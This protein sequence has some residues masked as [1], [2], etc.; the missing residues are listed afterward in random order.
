MSVS[1]SDAT[2]QTEPA[3]P[4]QATTADA[5]RA[6]PPPQAP[7]P[8]PLPGAS[9][10]LG[11]AGRSFWPWPVLALLVVASAGALGPSWP[12]AALASVA[13]LVVGLVGQWSVAGWRWLAVPVLVAVGVG[14][15]LGLLALERSSGAVARDAERGPDGDLRG[16]TLSREMLGSLD[17]VGRDLRGAQLARLDLRRE[18]LRGADAAGASFADSSLAGVDMRGADLRGADLRSTCLRD[19]NLRGALL[20]GADARGADVGAGVA[21]ADSTRLDGYAPGVDTG[22]CSRFP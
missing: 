3:G 15:F 14:T 8:R 20:D 22:A 21:G 11:R 2:G 12:P 10:L 1:E 16:R 4:G 19:A 17:L 6:A 7:H 5:H 9:A 18:S 13:V